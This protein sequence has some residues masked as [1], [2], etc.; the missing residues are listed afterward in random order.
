MRNALG[1]PQTLLLLGGTS[2]IGLAVVQA[3][4][5]PATRTVVLACRDT[6]AGR[7]A[8][9]TLARPGLTVE[10]VEF[11]ADRHD[12]H[13]TLLSDAARRHGDLDVIV[14]AVGVLAD[15]ETIADDPVTAAAVFTSNATG[16]VALLVASAAHVRQQ[17]HGH[18]VVLSSVAG[19]RARASLAVYG[20]AKAG[21]DATAQ[22]LGDQLEGSGASVLIVRPGF[23]R[24][25]MTA[26]LPDAPFATTPAMVGAATAAALK[27]GR[28]IVWVPGVLRWVFMVLRHLP[29]P[30][31]RRIAARA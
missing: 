21:L 19:E 22:A 27:R 9:A 8:A 16:P 31:W 17:G 12:T 13:V 4:V 18:L 2:D 24:S 11:Q 10:V 30:L 7:R 25:R 23:V 20:G 26:G 28:R 14:M 1:E 5:S 15:T 3:L 6:A 29:A